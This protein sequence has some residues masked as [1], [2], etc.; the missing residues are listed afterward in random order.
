[1]ITETEKRIKSTVLN[2]S[3][4]LIIRNLDQ[5]KEKQ[6]ISLNYVKSCRYQQKIEGFWMCLKMKKK[7]KSTGFWLIC[8]VWMYILTTISYIFKIKVEAEIRLHKQK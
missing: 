6:R 3:H 7:R 8:L 5:S 1:V 2:N 4:S